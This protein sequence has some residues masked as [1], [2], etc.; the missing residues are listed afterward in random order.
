MILRGH[1]LNGARGLNG[2]RSFSGRPLQYHWPQWPANE[3]IETM[4]ETNKGT[5]GLNKSGTIGLNKS[6]A[7]H[8]D[9][10]FWENGRV[11]KL[12][13]FADACGREV[14][15]HHSCVAM[16]SDCRSRYP[17]LSFLS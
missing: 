4:I 3:A 15:G 5:I 12:R 7:T 10:G 16:L 8:F 2:V 13:G 14:R 11:S 17:L 9:H 1:V 6:E